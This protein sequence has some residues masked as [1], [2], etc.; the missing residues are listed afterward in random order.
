MQKIPGISLGYFLH[1]VFDYSL[2][3]LYILPMSDFKDF[4]GVIFNIERNSIISNAETI[5][6][7]LKVGKMLCKIKWRQ[8]R[9]V[10]LE[11]LL[12]L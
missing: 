8:R 6:P 11:L 12:N 10:E 3:Y 2:N 9:Q 5:F 4:S 7:K 1:L